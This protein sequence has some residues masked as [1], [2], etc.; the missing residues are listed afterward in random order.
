MKKMIFGIILFGIGLD[1]FSEVILTGIMDGTLTGGKPKAIE[2][3]IT[4]AEDLGGYEIWRSQNGDPFGSGSGSIASLSGTYSNT[5]VYLV[6]SDHVVEFHNVF[7]DT[8]YFANV[9]PLSVVSGNG[10]EGFQIRDT[11]GDVIIDQVWQEDPTYSYSDSYWYRINGTG[12]DGDWLVTHWESPGN[13]ALDG[14]DE[15]GLRATVPFG[16]Y[17]LVWKGL[18]DDWNDM[19]NWMPGLAPS[20][21]CNVFIPDTVSIFPIIENSPESPAECYAL[22]LAAGATLT[23]G[24]G[25]AITVYGN[26]LIEGWLTSDRFILE[27]DSSLAPAGSLLFRGEEI[28]SIMVRRYIPDDNSWHFLSSPVT[29]QA[30]QPEFAPDPLDSSFDLYCWQEGVPLSEGWMNI[31]DENGNLNPLFESE[32][33][34]GKGYLLA[35][36][37]QYSGNPMKSFN[38]IPHHGDSEWQITANG[39]QWNL[40]GNPY[41]CAMDWSSGGID[42]T[43]VSGGAMY[44][45]DQSLNNGAGAYRTH[46]GTSGVPAGTTPL[47]PAINGF[48]VH[49]ISSGII[50]VDASSD[51]LLVHASQNYY[52]H[53][54]Q[55]QSEQIRLA[56]SRDNYSDETMIVF[57]PFASNGY[58]HELD[59]LKLSNGVDPAPEISSIAEGNLELCINQLGSHPASVPLHI[60]YGYADTLRFSA[61]DF[62]GLSPAVGIFLEDVSSGIWQDLREEP[63]YAFLNEVPGTPQRLILHF[64]DVTGTDKAKGTSNQYYSAF[65]S[66]NSIYI[67][68]DIYEPALYYLID[69]SGKVISSGKTEGKI[70][71]NRAAQ[72]MYILLFIIGEEYNRIKI[73]I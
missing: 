57:N 39:N 48:F 27:S 11:V 65:V 43:L 72:G 59:A 3:F 30:I 41:T 46:N 14:L 17:S 47:I 2:L 61:F 62:D 29:G 53:M 52:K 23:V 66:G 68:G 22:S 21:Y 33:T 51:S 45:W 4:G 1:V 25:K 36:S 8:G 26:L 32:F 37:G 58:D 55:P 63:D 35:Y 50:P 40:M 31:R 38:G 20:Q 16:S 49:A 73:I 15:E 18:N 5:F 13:D 19:A 60:N 67:T 64:T 6:K 69:I 44:I 12:P 56:L 42:K 7:G 10:N 9:I 24:A 28:D 54:M 71:L 34:L 70:G